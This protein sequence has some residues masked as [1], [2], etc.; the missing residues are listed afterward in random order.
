[1]S[2][3]EKSSGRLRWRST[4]LGGAGMRR[5]SRAVGLRSATSMSS[6]EKSSGR[7]RW[8]STPLGGAGMRRCSRTVGLRSATSMPSS[9]K[10]SGRLRWRS[11]P[12]G[13]AGMRRCSRAVGLA[14]VSPTMPHRPVTDDLHIMM[15]SVYVVVERPGGPLGAATS[16]ARTTGRG[17]LRSNRV[18]G[19]RST[20][21]AAAPTR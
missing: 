2:S 1:M 13:G 6:R 7:L 18:S 21:S 3:R 15:H 14:L 11:T 12:L 16:D 8:R 20:W 4:P 5:R 9:E 17:R 19:C 10:S